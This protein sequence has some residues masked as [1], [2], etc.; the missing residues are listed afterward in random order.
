MKSLRSSFIVDLGCRVDI[1]GVMVALDRTWRA[2]RRRR[3]IEMECWT[4]PSSDYELAQAALLAAGLT[5]GLPVIPPTADRVQRMMAAAGV[6]PAG[7]LGML[8]PAF[9]DVTWQQVAI[10]A[11]MAGCTPACLKIVGAAIGAMCA[12]EFNL[13]GIATTTGSACPLVIVN[14]P[15]AVAAGMNPGANALGPG[16]AANA[17][18]GRAVGLVLRNVGG[19]IPGELDMATLGQPGKYSFCVAENEAL[20]P[21]APLHVERGFDRERGVVTVVGAAGSIEINDSSSSTPEDLAQTCA[22]SMPAAGNVGSAGTVGGG[23]PVLLMP[24]EH[25]TLFHRAGCSKQQAKALIHA[26]ARLP[27]DWLA[28]PMRRSLAEQGADLG[29]GWLPVGATPDDLLLVVC[30]G[31]GRKAAYIPSWSGQ[32]RAVSRAVD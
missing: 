29:R 31:V 17:S 2:P 3:R 20:S 11:V 5:D 8:P 9:V 28:E 27:L 15:A 21:W 30:G 7:T 12:D 1:C 22:G 10:N 32:T 6:D 4:G 25:A 24:P 26:R 23:E 14:G 19:A 13:L 18:I 16:N